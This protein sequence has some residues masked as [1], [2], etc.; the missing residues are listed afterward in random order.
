MNNEPMNWEV[1]EKD[2]SESEVNREQAK[3]YA[4]I[5]RGSVRLVRGLYRTEAE[6]RE[7]IDKGLS[8]CLPGQ[9]QK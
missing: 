9:R 1:L 4:V 7:F 8:I 3:R 5:Q 2:Y 6:Q